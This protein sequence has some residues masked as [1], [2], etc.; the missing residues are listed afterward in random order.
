MKATESLI[1]LFENDQ[2]QR[3]QCRGCGA[4]IEW[5]GT[6]KG[7]HMPMNAGAVPRKSE[8]DPETHRLI[9]FFAADDAHWSTC[10]EAKRFGRRS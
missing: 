1:R 9:V 3:A 2:P 5:F 8:H 6:L 4:D 7:K 10:P